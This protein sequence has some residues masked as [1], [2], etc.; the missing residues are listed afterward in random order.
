[1]A[2]LAIVVRFQFIGIHSWPDAPANQE[3]YLAYPHRHVFHVEAVLDVTHTERD[4]EFIALKEAM[5]EHCKHK[6]FEGPHN[7]SCE[8]MAMKLLN[9][10][11]LRRG[12]GFEGNENGAEVTA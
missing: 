6:G 1:M 11:E 10:F 9:R 3:S 4:V 2:K 5:I 7:L 12:R 8:L